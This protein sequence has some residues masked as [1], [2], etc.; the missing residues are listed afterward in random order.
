MKTRKIILI[1]AISVLLLLVGMNKSLAESKMQVIA[2]NEVIKQ[3]EETKIRI[4]LNNADIAALTLEIF[5]DNTKLEYISGPETSNYSNNR[6]IYTWANDK[7]IGE[8]I[9]NID[10]FNFKGITDGTANIVVTGNF[11]TPNGEIVDL[12]NANLQIRVGE[13]QVDEA[14]N[15]DEIK[16]KQKDVS[17]NNANLSVL[18]LN[19]EGISPEFNTDIKEYYFIAP[20]SITSLEVTAI[21]ENS[22]SI[23]LITGNTDL[24]IGKNVISIK[25]QSKDKS[26]TS[27]YVIYVTRTGNIDKANANLETLAIRQGALNPEFDPD[28]TKYKTEIANDV[29]KLDFLAIPQKENAT[30]NVSGNGEM[31][32]GNN[33][34]EIVVLAEDGITSKKYEIE[35]YRRNE[36]EEAKNKENQI[37]AQR[38]STALQ[39]QYFNNNVVSDENNN[40]EMDKKEYNMLLIGIAIVIVVCIVVITVVGFMKHRKK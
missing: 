37:E 9:I 19:H 28:I 34:I 31:K 33:K 22:G 25:V 17:D 14:E 39:E 29:D 7:G 1:L 4:E 21:P 38:I 10:G 18:R 20:E 3:G 6:I 11:Y 23:V 5:W 40:N 24:K 15:A 35:V 13:V 2:N 8:N 27:E 30:L 12:D 16:Q 36:N 26:T 32:V